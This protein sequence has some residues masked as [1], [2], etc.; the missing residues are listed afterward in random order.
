MNLFVFE[1]ISAAFTFAIS[2]S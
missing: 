1:H 2:P